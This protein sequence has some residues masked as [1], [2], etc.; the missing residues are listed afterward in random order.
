MPDFVERAVDVPEDVRAE[1]D[2]EQRRTVAEPVFGVPIEEV[3]EDAIAERD[4]EARL[5]QEEMRQRLTEG[6]PPAEDEPR[7]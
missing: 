2:A 1:L 5:G 3:P 7:S 4:L 6:R